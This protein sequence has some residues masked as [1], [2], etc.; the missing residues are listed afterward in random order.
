MHLDEED[1]HRTRAFARSL[2]PTNWEARFIHPQHYKI[3]TRQLIDGAAE[4]VELSCE[5]Q[6]SLAYVASDWFTFSHDT[7]SV[8]TGGLNLY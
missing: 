2:R 4:V 5:Q 6:R 8:G 1:L 7:D 3:A